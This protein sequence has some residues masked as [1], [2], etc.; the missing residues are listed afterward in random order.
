MQPAMCRWAIRQ[1][2]SLLRTFGQRKKESLSMTNTGQQSRSSIPNVLVKNKSL[3]RTKQNSCKA[4][5]NDFVCGLCQANCIKP[6]APERCSR[7][8]GNTG[9]NLSGSSGQSTDQRDN[10]S[11]IRRGSHRKYDDNENKN[12]ES[13]YQEVSH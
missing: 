6:I 1:D 9:A 4:K 5:K 10:P 12:Q 7:C 8:Y 13:T 2:Y 11:Q 3:K